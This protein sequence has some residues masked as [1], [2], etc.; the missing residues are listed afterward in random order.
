VVTPNEQNKLVFVGTFKYTA[1]GGAAKTVPSYVVYTPL[2]ED[3]FAEAIRAGLKL[4][5]YK[6]VVTYTPNRVDPKGVHITKTATKS[7][8][9]LSRLRCN[10]C[11][12]F[13]LATIC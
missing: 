9:K 11:F 8:E 7:K 13:M 4:V 6:L 10:K 1:A 12:S 5:S 3:Q 2:T